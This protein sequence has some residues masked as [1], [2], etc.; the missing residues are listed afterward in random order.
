MIEIILDASQL[1]VFE[2]CPFK[3]YLS[4]AQNLETKRVNPA[5]STGSF[6]HECLK[7]YYGRACAEKIALSDLIRP[8]I[9]YAKAIVGTSV[10][11][12]IDFWGQPHKLCGAEYPMIKKDPAFYLKRLVD[13]LYFNLDDDENAELIAVE[14]GFTW[15]LHEDD[16][17]RFLLEG[18]IDLVWKKK[19]MGLT[20]TDHKTQSMAYEKYFFNHQAL[21]YLSF[22]EADYFEYNFIGLQKEATIKTFRRPIFKPG[23]GV[24][25]QWKRDVFKTFLEMYTYQKL[26][27]DV[28]G[29]GD[30]TYVAFPRR[31][32]ACKSEF[33]LCQFTKRCQE[34]DD[35][36]FVRAIMSSVY[37][38][39]DEQWTAWK[40][41]STAS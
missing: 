22:T 6:Y 21:N 13:Y 14:Q 28:H 10:Y 26:Q 24:L 16:E 3:W 8:T 27:M 2:P 29:M 7:Y 38:S 1:E 15:L 12:R 18:M 30:T 40:A 9:E 37:K 41:T 39:K 36:K 20:I 34:P 32:S 33:G 5:L 31:R 11:P 25:A 17:K 35:S 4:Q 19:G 23:P